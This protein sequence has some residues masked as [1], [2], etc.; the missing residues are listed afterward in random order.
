MKL[1]YILAFLLFGLSASCQWKQ[2]LP[3]S[4]YNTE[5]KLFR[6]LDSSERITEC[7]QTLGAPLDVNF[8]Q[9]LIEPKKKML[10]LIGRT[11]F[12]RRSPNGFPGVGIY[13][14]EAKDGYIRT[15]DL[16]FDTDGLK[17]REPWEGGFFDITV[18]LKGKESL[19]FH[20]NATRLLQFEIYKL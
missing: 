1:F 19:F 4:V 8:F 20:N 6:C 12:T 5:T 13:L 17:V 9:V 14:T 10:R 11:V 7:Y 15:S 18:A 16:I 3:S 2:I